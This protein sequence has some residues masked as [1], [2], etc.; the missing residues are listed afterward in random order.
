M[1]V[2]VMSSW[3]GCKPGMPS[4]FPDADRV[5]KAQKNWCAMLAKAEAPEGEWRYQRACEQAHPTSSAAFLTRLTKC[6]ASE[7]EQLGDDSPDEAIMMDVC[8]NEVFA[9][10]D[11]GEAKITTLVAARCR[12]T[13]KCTPITY[14]ECTEAFED[15]D[16]ALRL[17]LTDM[18]N[19]RAQYE[20]ASCLDDGACTKD[21]DTAMGACYDVQTER[22]AWFTT[23]LGH[24]G[25]D[26][27]ITPSK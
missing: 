4:S 25:G 21:E 14:P 5:V 10:S 16:A 24:D 22:R 23:M 19:L 15:L 27:T 1:A 8:T 7:Y 9:T 2:V 11:P 18:Y 20:I 6:F 12:R 13:A 26:V 3:M 17:L